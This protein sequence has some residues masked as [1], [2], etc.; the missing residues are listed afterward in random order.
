VGLGIGIYLGRKHVVAASAEKTAGGYRLKDYAIEPVPP[1]SE[2]VEAPEGDKKLSGEGLAIQ[3]ALQKLKVRRTFARLAISPFY[4]VTRYFIM[5]TLPEKEK[6]EAIRYEASRHTRLKLTESVFAYHEYPYVQ[7]VSA[8]TANAVKRR[9]IQLAT[10]NA[11]RAGVDP[12]VIEPDYI[13]FSRTAAYFGLTDFKKPQ[14]FVWCDSDQSI[15]LTLVSKGIVFLSHDFRLSGDAAAD[16]DK[17]HDEL[18][19]AARYLSESAGGFAIELFI[20]SGFGALESWAEKSFFNRRKCKFYGTLSE[21]QQLRM[22][23]VHWPSLWGW[24]SVTRDGNPRSAKFL[25]FRLKSVS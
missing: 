10:M 21:I 17:F 9:Q 25:C 13:S 23:P 4:V 19:G 16:N 12:D 14:C 3:N 7:N 8:I 22:I 11:R 5:P 20:V 18:M 2:G 24:R 15:S 1:S 6:D